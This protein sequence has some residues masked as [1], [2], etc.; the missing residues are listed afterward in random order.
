MGLVATAVA[1]FEVE[2]DMLL[3]D[4]EAEGCVVVDMDGRVE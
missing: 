2:A 1:G 4:E 3:G